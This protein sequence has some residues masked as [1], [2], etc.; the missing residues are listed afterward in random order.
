MGVGVCVCVGVGVCGCVCVGVCVGV[1]IP[2]FK[3]TYCVDLRLLL[4]L[5][6][7]VIAFALSIFVFA[8]FVTNVSG[9]YIRPIFRVRTLMMDEHSI[10]KRWS[11]TKQ[12]RR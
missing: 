4:G 11:Q 7:V 6:Y 1:S 8:W 10:P 9:L 2:S 12:K 3:N 5:Q